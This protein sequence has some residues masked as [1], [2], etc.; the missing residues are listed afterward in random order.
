MMVVVMMKITV[1]MMMMVTA[2]ESDLTGEADRTRM[3]G[4]VGAAFGIGFIVGPALGGTLVS[5]DPHYPALA[6]AFLSLMNLIGMGGR[7][8][9][10]VRYLTFLG[11][12]G[13][14]FFMPE[15]LSKEKIALAQSIRMKNRASVPIL[16][17]PACS[18]DLPLIS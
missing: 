7:D 3:L 2:M 11:T 16:R 4:L 17:F 15:S 5:W 6:A 8:V 13:V 10:S 1:M 9:L 14:Y 12:L 18:A